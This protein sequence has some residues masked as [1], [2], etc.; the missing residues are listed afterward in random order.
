[1]AEAKQISYTPAGPVVKAFHKSDAFI[2]GIKGPI[3]SGKSTACVIELLRRAQMQEPDSDGIRRTRFAII[4]N[5][6]PD[7]KNTT[8]PTWIQWMPAE[9]GKFTWSVPLKHHVK[10]KELD[11][12]FIFLGLDNDDDVRKVMSLEVTGAWI[13]EARFIP[14]TILDALTGRVGR[15]PKKEGG[16]GGAT[17]AGVLM[18]TNPPDTEHFWYKMATKSDPKME[19][20]VSKLTRDLVLMGALKENQPLIEFFDQPSGLSPDAENLPNLRTGYYQFASVG[21]DEDYLKVY[22]HGEYGFVAE[23]RPVWP[24]YRHHLHASNEVIEPVAGV[25]LLIGADLGLTPAAVIGQRLADGRWLTIDELVTDDCGT[26]RFADLLA[27]HVARKYPEFEV[28]AGFVDPAAM[29][30]SQNDEKTPIDIL[31]QHTKWKWHPAPSNSFDIRREAV[32]N[33]LNRLVDGNAGILMSS[34]CPTLIKGCVSGYHFKFVRSSNGAQVHETPVK[35]QYSHVCEA[36]QY[37]LLGGGEHAQV[38]NLKKR[39]NQGVVIAR[40]TGSEVF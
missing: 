18:D 40:D 23:G 4:R 26:I 24:M 13:N 7:L 17:W 29:V 10:T 19:A 39:Q 15:Y 30:R 20:E 2:R 33:T 3:G 16:K 32:V 25:P 5:T 1:M 12:E 28:S 38:F 35:N 21:K 6:M 36:L 37:L 34:T 22:I 31:K 14:K 11:M 9:F 27:A 8:I